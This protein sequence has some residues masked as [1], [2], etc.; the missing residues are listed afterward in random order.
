ME[1]SNNLKRKHVVHTSESSE[2]HIINDPSWLQSSD[3]I[4]TSQHH[5][6][7]HPL[8]W[9]GKAEKCFKK[10]IS[11]KTI[12]L[13]KNMDMQQNLEVELQQLKTSL[14][15]LKNFE[16]D[17]EEEVDLESFNKVNALENELTEK[18]VL[19]EELEALNQVLMTK[20]RDMNDELQNARKTLINGIEELSVPTNIAV[21]RM[22][23]LDSEPFL[24]AMKKKYKEEEA[25]VRAANLCSLWE[26]YMKDAEWYPFKLVTVDGKE[27]EV[28]DDAD[29]KLNGL[30]R[31]VGKA[32]YNAVVAALTE[33]NEYN[34]SGRYVT[35]E[36][37]N[38]DEDRRATLQ[39]GIQCLLDNSSNKC[40]KGKETMGRKG[41]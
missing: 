32:A 24:E 28:I 35:S 29:K 36:L 10:Q 9:I 12:E 33:L 27:R 18:E 4:Q 20:E 1:N 2:N 7:H 37:W 41:D 25:E 31:S 40:E 3:D 16:D 23:E 21:K 39:E 11:A 19:I 8:G 5:A 13:E 26:F 30:K 34:S 15:V 22:G 38:N 14:N 6:H 17:D